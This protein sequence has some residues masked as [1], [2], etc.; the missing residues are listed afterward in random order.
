MLCSNRVIGK[1]TIYPIPVNPLSVICGSLLID[2]FAS[3]CFFC[4]RLMLLGVHLEY[5]P[6]GKAKAVKY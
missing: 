3:M 1:G 2:K 5:V 4:S 6:H